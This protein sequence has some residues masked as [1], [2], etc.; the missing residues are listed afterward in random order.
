MRYFIVTVFVCFLIA[1]T[2]AQQHHFIY[3]QTENKQPFYVKL[4]KKIFTSTIFGYLII[5]KLKDGKLNISI[6]F[7]KDEWPVQNIEFEMPNKDQGFLLKN[8]GTKGWGLFNMQNLNIVMATSYSNPL[9]AYNKN[10]EGDEFSTLLST[11]VKDPSIKSTD[12]TS[13]INIKTKPPVSPTLKI[14]SQSSKNDSNQANLIENQNVYI[15]KLSQLNTGNSITITYIIKSQLNNDTILI[16]LDNLE[17]NITNHT[18]KD[19]IPTSTLSNLKIDSSKNFPLNPTNNQVKLQ[20]NDNQQS[21]IIDTTFA[22]KSE[23]VI[24]SNP[25]N[26]VIETKQAI[27]NSNCTNQASEDDFLKLRKRMAAEQNE[28]SM[29]KLAKKQFKAKC[30]STEQVKNLANLFLNDKGKYSFLD[31]AYPFVSDSYNFPTVQIILIDEYYISRFKAMIR[32]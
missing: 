14:N 8:F 24:S 10:T 23:T 19:S 31:T 4:D 5:P 26:Q 9:E 6:G 7:P 22:N 21:N 16:N 30:F 20:N 11:V 13:T 17:D 3:I 27:N 29:L 2:Q 1:V 15:Q 18:L 25:N 12:Q 32:H 28:E